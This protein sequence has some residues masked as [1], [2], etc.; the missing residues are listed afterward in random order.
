MTRM[1]IVATT[2]AMT[3]GHTALAQNEHRGN[4]QPQFVPCNTLLDADVVSRQDK[5]RGADLVDFVVDSRT[6]RIAYAVIDTEGILGVDDRQVAIP[7][8]ALS[9]NSRDRYLIDTSAQEL[10]NLPKWDVDNL[11]HLHDESWHSTMRGVFGDR[12]E[13]RENENFHGDEYSELWGRQEAK[14]IEGKVVGVN[15]EKKTT[16]GERC[17]SIIVEDDSTREQRTI[18]LAPITHLSN[19]K[20]IPSEGQKVSLT[21]VKSFDGDGETVYV[22]DTIRYGGNNIRLR[23]EDGTPAWKNGDSRSRQTYYVLASKMQDG[24]VYGQGEEFGA[25]HEVLIEPYSG[26]ASFATVSVGG[27]LGMGDT[28]YVIP[29]NAITMGNKYNYYIDWPVSKLKLAPKLSDNG[30]EDLNNREF[31]QRVNEYYDVRQPRYNT[32]R[33]ND[34]A[35]TRDIADADD[36]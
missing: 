1:L 5:E 29:R 24:T 21:A 3:L 22:A 35:R 9:W 6:G 19:E 25:V 34:W 26:T 11:G 12:N 31:V 4:P 13:L 33:S 28:L 2:G 23:S 10:R 30:V 20:E 36:N 16:R 7:Y 14:T 32:N 17:Y 8:G 27:V 18:V 15:R